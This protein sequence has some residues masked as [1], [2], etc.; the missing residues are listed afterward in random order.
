MSLKGKVKWTVFCDAIRTVM[1]NG[2]YV[3]G[4]SGC[5]YW[6]CGGKLIEINCWIMWFGFISKH[7]LESVIK[8]KCMPSLT[9]LSR[10]FL[11]ISVSEIIIKFTR[12]KNLNVQ[13]KSY[14]VMLCWAVWLYL[15]LWWQFFNLVVRP[16]HLIVR[17]VLSF[18]STGKI[19]QS[20]KLIA[21]V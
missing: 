8:I 2:S 3:L 10:L 15:W 9:Q 21:A 11:K 17:E 4:T 18:F 13:I 14:P 16:S 5:S 6:Q 19:S 12:K 1:W 7:G 20:V